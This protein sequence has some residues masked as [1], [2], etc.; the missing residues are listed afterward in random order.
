MNPK[1]MEVRIIFNLVLSFFFD[2]LE[3][4]IDNLSSDFNKRNFFIIL[5]L[6]FVCYLMVLKENYTIL[7]ITINYFFYTLYNYYSCL[8]RISK[9]KS[10]KTNSLPTKQLKNSNLFINTSTIINADIQT[11][12]KEVE[13]KS[14][15]NYLL[16]KDLEAVV[17]NHQNTHYRANRVKIPYLYDN[18]FV[19]IM[20]LE[21]KISSDGMVITKFNFLVSTIK[22]TCPIVK[23]ARETLEFTDSLFYSIIDNSLEFSNKENIERKIA[24]SKNTKISSN[25]NSINE[26]SNLNS[27]DN[28]INSINNTSN[29]VK[30]EKKTHP[31]VKNLT[32]LTDEEI[33]ICE[34]N[35]KAFINFK[36]NYLNKKWNEN[37]RDKKTNFV[38]SIQDD[39]KGRRATKSTIIINNDYKIVYDYIME[40][41]NKKSYDK[42]YDRG[43]VLKEMNE[44]YGLVWFAYKGKLGVSGR[45]F[46]CCIKSENFENEKWAY[47]FAS[48]FKGYPGYDEVKPYYRAN[49]IFSYYYIFQLEDGTTQVD[50]YVL[51]ETGISQWIMNLALKDVSIAMKGIKKDCD[52][53]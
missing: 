37:D 29:I 52:K 4:K 53:K 1:R 41:D 32:N 42:S 16:H 14:T 39:E 36:E 21:E 15:L 23:I 12:I 30:E 46:L 27:T 51:S 48:S 43:V 35:E 34:S 40:L 47:I 33:L 3:N 10:S 50:F 28:T 26:E 18:Q 19:T 8:S 45:D 2:E 13:K 11:V 44:T 9:I 20:T 24:K 6:I 49:L 5:L 31:Y 22:L 38:F 7:I 25:L 17:V